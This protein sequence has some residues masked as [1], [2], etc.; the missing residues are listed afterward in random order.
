[1][2][3]VLEQSRESQK[4]RETDSESDVFFIYL[5]GLYWIDFKVSTLDGAHVPFLEIKSNHHYHIESQ[6]EHLKKRS[7]VSFTL[8]LSRRSLKLIINDNR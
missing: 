5:S 7:H 8:S 4:T 3:H 2:N 1:M 6:S